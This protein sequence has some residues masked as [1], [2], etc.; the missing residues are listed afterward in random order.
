MSQLK[1]T[2][3]T[4]TTAQYDNTSNLAQKLSSYT[5]QI[6]NATDRF[7]TMQST[8][9]K[10]YNAMEVALQQLSAQSSWLSSMLGT[11]TSSG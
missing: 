11:S 1:Q 9:Y 10:Q 6:S 3:G 7:N 5:T 4:T 8:Y 2:A